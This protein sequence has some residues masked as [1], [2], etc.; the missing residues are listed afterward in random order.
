[1]NKKAAMRNKAMNTRIIKKENVSPFTDPATKI[2][3][4]WPAIYRLNKVFIL[5][6]L[7][8]VLTIGVMFQAANFSPA[9]YALTS[10]C[11]LSILSGSVD[12][13]IPETNDT[14]PGTDGM[15]LDAG[16]RV[17]TSPDSTALLTFFDGSTLTLEPGTDIEIEQLELG[18]NQQT[19][20]IILKQWTGKTWSHVVKMADKGS[21]Y[22]I[23]TP[24]AVAL[25]RG[26]QFLTVVV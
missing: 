6:A 10:K 8:V 12:V 24:S 25:V 21:H 13:I 3:R 20:T 16:N 17:K 19:I 11:T 22:E 7:A 4:L 18:D 26:T 1:L 9:S 14:Q 15:T 5:V 23:R 2:Q